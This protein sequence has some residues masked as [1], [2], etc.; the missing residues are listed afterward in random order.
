MSYGL[1][2]HEHS[3]F[4]RMYKG[5]TRSVSDYELTRILLILLSCMRQMALIVAVRLS[6]PIS[7]GFEFPMLHHWVSC[8]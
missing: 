5:T 1:G 3:Y 8:P 6:F 7:H 2:K 4:E